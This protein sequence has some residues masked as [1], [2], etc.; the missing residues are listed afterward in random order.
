MAKAKVIIPIVFWA[1]LEPWLKAIK[2]AEA[3]CTFLKIPATAPGRVWR[4]SHKREVITTSPM[5]NPIMGA[6]TKPKNTFLHPAQIKTFVPAVAI[7]APAKPDISPW[8]SLVGRPK[9]VAKELQ[10]ITEVRAIAIVRRL[11]DS[12]VTKPFPI[13]TATAVPEKAPTRLKNAAIKTAV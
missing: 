10:I 2:A 5:T 12:V 13:V 4:K 3:I 1:S 8:L 11:I 7:P 6:K 9:T